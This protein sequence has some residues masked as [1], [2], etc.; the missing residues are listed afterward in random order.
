LE[1]EGIYAEP[2]F[3]KDINQCYF[4]H[5]IELPGYG[6]IAGNW[7]L[8]SGID[9][10]LG[11]IDFTGKRVLDIGSA[12]GMLCFEMERRGAEVVAFDLSKE[13]GWDLVPF[14]RWEEYEHISK[15]HHQMIDRLNNAYW[16]C[17]RCLRSNAKV[18]YGSVYAI[19]EEIGSVDIAVYG[20]ILLHVRDP[21]LAL[22]NGARLTRET[23]IVTEVLRGQKIKSNEPYMQFLPDAETMEPKDTWWD[24]RPELVVRIMQVMG[25]EKTHILYHAQMYEGNKTDLYTVVGQRRSWP[26]ASE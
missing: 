6:T 14:A 9:D 12:N 23:L 20:S 26:P 3:I 7:D 11:R 5:T 2:R 1:H 25:F 15:V 8:R 21:F 4:Y 10:Y 16:F 19:P 22:Q 24:L 17:H 13:Y 18:V